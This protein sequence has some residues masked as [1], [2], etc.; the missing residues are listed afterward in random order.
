M[1]AK[2]YNFPVQEQAPPPSIKDIID[3]TV[4][5]HDGYMVDLFLDMVDDIMKS[6]LKNSPR[7]EVYADLLILRYTLSKYCLV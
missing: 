4:Q 7:E 2:I 3:K 6:M 1:S 5:E